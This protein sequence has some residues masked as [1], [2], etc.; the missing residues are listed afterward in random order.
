M[1]YIKKPPC[2]ITT[3]QQD[4]LLFFPEISE[5]FNEPYS[6]SEYSSNNS[7]PSFTVKRKAEEE[8]PDAVALKRLK[9]FLL[10]FIS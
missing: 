10:I 1:C 5:L 8:V 9:V 2:E 6:P 3:Q 4:P 7:C